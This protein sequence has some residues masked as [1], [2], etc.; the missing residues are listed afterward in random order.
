MAEKRKD[1]KGRL[2]RSGERQRKD[3]R[4]QYRYVDLD[5]V[6]Q[7]VYSWKLVETDSVPYGRKNDLSLREKEKEIAE[8]LEI[9]MGR[10]GKITL[11]MMF[12]SYVVRKRYRG[13]PLN[14]NTVTN[15]KQM[16]D[17]RIRPKAIGGKKIIEIKKKDITDLYL[18]LQEEGLSYGTITLFHKILS[19]VFNMAI[20]DDMVLKNPTRRSLDV[21]K[22]NRESKDAL[23]VE[24]Q[25]GL[26]AYAKKTNHEMYNKLVVLFDTMCRISE[27]AGL[28]WS[29]VDMKNRVITI[30]HQLQYLKLEGDE[31]VSFH[32]TPPKSKSGYRKIPMTNT[33]YQV[34]KEMKQYYFILKK[35]YEVDGV[36]DFLFYSAR[37]KLINESNFSNELKRLV[38]QYNEKAKHKIGKITPH[39]L[40]HTGCTR[41]AEAGMDIRV[42]QYL[43][44]HSNPFTTNQ[45]YNH[46]DEERAKSSIEAVQVLKNA[47]N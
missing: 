32:I 1:S 30:D 28:T 25:K 41:N 22:V 13:Q 12:D 44:G 5:G 7:N 40:R 34:L 42:L 46:V 19:A 37:D 29:D 36:Q 31:K 4:Y 38:S 10:G 9:G 3:G 39:I 2:L 17:K 8:F 14:E 43:M 15:Y 24:Q 16:W 47:L 33:V 45:V 20:D 23:S 27:F 26:L 21:V 35:D 11:N 18:Q 6:V